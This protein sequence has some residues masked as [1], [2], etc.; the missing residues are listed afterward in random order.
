[1]KRFIIE[2][3]DEEF[4]TSHSGLALVGLC[5]NR[6]SELSHVIGR[7]MDKRGNVISHSDLLRSYLGLLCLGKSDYLKFRDWINSLRQRSYFEITSAL[8]AVFQ[9]P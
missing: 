2:Q 4:Y 1:M 9:L 5:I 8:I 7:K 3:S 6:Y